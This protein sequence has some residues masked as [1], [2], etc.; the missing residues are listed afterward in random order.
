M[1]QDKHPVH[2]IRRENKYRLRFQYPHILPPLPQGANADRRVGLTFDI[3]DIQQLVL[4]AE[5]KE[6]G[7]ER[8]EM[9]FRSQMKDLGVVRMVYV[10]EDTE[11]L[12]VYV[13]GG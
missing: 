12:A 9:G 10:G 6:M 4:F 11:E 2:K 5:S 8:V 1:F 3:L 13:F 7:K